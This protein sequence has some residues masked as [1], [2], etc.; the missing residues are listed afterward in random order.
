[1]VVRRKQHV[2]CS[3]C[4]CGLNKLVN[5]ERSS[6]EKTRIRTGFEAI[7][8]LRF[9]ELIILCWFIMQFSCW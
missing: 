1:M 2:H 7:R 8:S 6:Q 9:I 4:E 3:N 5:L